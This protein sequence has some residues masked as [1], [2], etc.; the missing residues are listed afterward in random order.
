MIIF[1][2]EEQAGEAWE[3]S[4]K[5]VLLLKLEAL[6]RKHFYVCHEQGGCAKGKT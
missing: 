4:N 3:P 2:L 6:E 1:S 5:A